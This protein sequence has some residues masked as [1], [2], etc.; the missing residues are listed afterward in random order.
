MNG[1][2]AAGNPCDFSQVQGLIAAGDS[3]LLDLVG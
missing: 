2:G 3:F 1:I